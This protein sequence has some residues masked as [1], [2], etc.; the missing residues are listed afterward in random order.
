MARVKQVGIKQVGIKQTG[1]IRAACWPVVCIARLA[2]MS[3]APVQQ[4][5]EGSND[6][7]S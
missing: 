3:L 2:D 7:R 4:F 5:W 1:L 6:D